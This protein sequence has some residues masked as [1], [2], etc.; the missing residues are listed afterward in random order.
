MI[1]E[2]IAL[3]KTDML[4]I[5]NVN[6]HSYLDV[7]N[8]AEYKKYLFILYKIQNDGY[9]NLNNVL[10]SKDNDKYNIIAKFIDKYIHVCTI[11]EITKLDK[12]Y[13]LDEYKELL[14]N[15]YVVEFVKYLN[16]YNLCIIL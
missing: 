5:F 16:G 10:D 2:I 8:E 13:Q 6:Q 12:I 9:T 7:L 3:D 4:R 14:N 1:S 11:I 15:E